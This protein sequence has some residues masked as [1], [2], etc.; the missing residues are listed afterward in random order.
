MTSSMTLLRFQFDHLGVD[1]INLVIIGQSKDILEII[2]SKILTQKFKAIPVVSKY[3]LVVLAQAIHFHNWNQKVKDQ[4]ASEVFEP[5]MIAVVVVS[6]LKCFGYFF[7]SEFFTRCPRTQIE[8]VETNGN[9]PSR[10][11]IKTSIRSKFC[12]E[13]S[14][15]GINCAE[16]ESDP[17]RVCCR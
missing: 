7:G 8:R 16:V 14:A 11:R 4:N 2:R 6:L 10:F 15:R 3:S 5:E 17:N 1:I 9:L 13:Q 12:F